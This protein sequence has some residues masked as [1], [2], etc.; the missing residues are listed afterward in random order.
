MNPLK[1]LQD[2]GQ[3]IW[4]DD[5]RRSLVTSGQLQTLIT[6]DGLRGITSNPST[7]EKAIGGSTDYDDALKAMERE[8]DLDARAIH[9]RLA[10]EDIKMAA[11]MLRPV[12]DATRR[13]DGFISIEVSPYLA[14]DTAA[15]IAEA[16]R[17]WHAIGR[18]NLM[19]K[20]PATAAG[21]PA[22]LQLTGEGINVNI[23]LLFSRTVYEAVAEAYLAGLEALLARG[24]N[25]LRTASVASFF[26]S[27]VDTAVDTLL[28]ERLRQTNRPAERAALQDLL[29][30]AAI[31]NAKLAYQRYKE[32][33]R[34]ERWDRL[35]QVGARPQRLLWASTGT[36]NPR[37]SDV[38]YV[39]EL[40]GP[41]TVSTIPPA[42]MDAFRNHGRPRASLE[43]GVAEARQVMAALDRLGV[44]LDDI[45]DKL[46]ADGVRL[47]CDA[48]D[49]LLGAIAR[50]HAAAL[51][52]G[53]D[54]ERR[55]AR[56]V[57]RKWRQ[58][59]G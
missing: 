42:T 11:D 15:T 59:A 28:E 17:L 6:E 26:V 39:E 46:T 24:G 30:K 27:R 36:K 16:R 7:F 49:K 37:Y 54:R 33:F 57:A 31:A 40:V 52:G 19:V 55:S 23:T 45:T 35:R 2:F 29:G 34:G 38:R 3:S 58:S 53:L 1:A 41:D 43:E 44:S 8:R 32:I 18:E 47:F 12:Y 50:K 22:I 51:A 10:V 4:L 21:L 25:A 13:R 9:G 5:F 14:T 20:V 56:S 48:E